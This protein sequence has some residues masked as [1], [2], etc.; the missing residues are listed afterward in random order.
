MPALPRFLLPLLGLC[1]ALAAAPAAATLRVFVSVPP[2]APLAQRVG[3]PTVEVRTLVGQNQDPHSFEP[4]AR[5]VQA[6]AAAEVFW[7]VGMPYERAWLP[8]LRAANPDLRVVDART[9]LGLPPLGQAAGPAHAPHGH[10]H[11][12]DHDP[13]ADPHLWTSPRAV[14][15]MV[16]PLAEAF[17][18]ADPAN[19]P[20]YRANATALDAELAALDAEVRAAL[21]PL[22]ARRFVVFH[23]AW[24]Q[25]A[26][27]Y[28]LEQI[29]IEQAGKEPTAR[30]LAALATRLR[31]EGVR[32][33]FVQPQTGR[34]SAE[35]L[36][37]EIGARLALLDPMA[38]DPVQGTRD[39]VRA[40]AEAQAP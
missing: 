13:A 40:L 9:A 21:A 17:A 28:G 18:A 20:A 24:G 16:E 33:V 7:A 37:R 4:S 26:A 1:A 3:G 38:A 15:A 5:Q 29:A 39:L 23:P 31:A 2:L 12:H 25:F 22:R 14:R 19:G 27:D 32:V 6:L 10:G 30:A 8:R 36:A 11:A 34:R 35:T